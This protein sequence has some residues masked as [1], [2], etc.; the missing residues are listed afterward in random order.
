M[1][2]CRASN[3][4][5]AAAETPSVTHTPPRSRAARAVPRVRPPTDSMTRSYLGEGGISS[6]TTTSWAP[7]WRSAGPWSARRALAVTCAPAS[8][9][10]C[11]AKSPTPPVAPVTSTRRPRSSPPFARAWSAVSPATGKV[12]AC[13]N[14]TLSGSSARACVGTATRFAHAPS[15]KSPTTRAPTR[16]PE[17][18][19]AARSTSPARSQP[20]RQPATAVPERLTSPRLSEKARTRTTAPLRSGTG[21][22]TGRMTSWPGASGSTTTARL[23][24]TGHPR[25]KG[26]DTRVAR[27]MRGATP[28]A[29]S[30]V[31]A[32]ES[33]PSENR[34]GRPGEG[35]STMNIGISVPLPAYLV[36]V[37]FM[38]RKA[39][40]LGFESFWCAEHPFIPVQSTSRFPG[41]EDGVI[42]ESYSHF[43]D[44]F[45]ALARASG[46]TSRV[47]LGTGIVLAPERH[48]LL[49]AK[50][51]STLDLF[52]G[53]RFLFGIGAGWLREETEIMGGDFDHRWTQTRE[54]ILAMKELWTKPEAEFHGRY[55]NFPPVRSYPKP[56][57]KPHPPVLL[58]GGAKNVLQRIVAWGDGWLPNRITP[59]QLRESR[60]TLDRLAKEA[61]RDPSAITI[62]VHGQPADRDLIKRLHDAG[63]NR[64][65]IRPETMKT[66]ADMAA[67]LTRIAEAVLR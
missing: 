60:A 36:D 65:V 30:S 3:V 57:Q 14:V 55:Y 34:P 16:G 46:V 9:A 28:A 24:L 17:P 52:S 18:S 56:A 22:A 40:E 29:V 11:T 27:S 15:G 5:S 33:R 63:A 4:A 10:S 19:A 13:E 53:G 38:A 8:R 37:G 67:E 25:R 61:G 1:K 50:E 54:S 64:V 21:S 44:P 49:L 47:K 42:P 45:V 23:A 26:T 51:I 39:E 12:A 48:P 31:R 59:D 43:I 20:G 2:N 35:V 62:S 32:N 58:G 41:S 7:S 66:E 6:P